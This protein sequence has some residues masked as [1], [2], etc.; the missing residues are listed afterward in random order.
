MHTRCQFLEQAPLGLAAI[1]V[2]RGGLR[3]AAAMPVK[4]ENSHQ[5]SPASA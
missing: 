2:C 3:E 5:K 1:V 4:A